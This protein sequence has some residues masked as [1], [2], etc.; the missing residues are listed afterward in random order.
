MQVLL[1]IVAGVVWWGQAVA[2][3]PPAIS[4][5]YTRLLA[6]PHGPDFRAYGLV[7]VLPWL[8]LCDRVS[9]TLARSV[10]PHRPPPTLST[11]QLLLRLGMPATGA[12]AMKER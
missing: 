11:E 2:L 3:V 5:P 8:I 7:G 6:F 10:F 9:S 4:F 12:E 1:A